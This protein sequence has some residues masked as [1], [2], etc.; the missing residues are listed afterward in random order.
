M[1]TAIEVENLGKLYRIQGRTVPTLKTTVID[2][3]R[4]RARK[5]FWALRH[6]T[7]RVPKGITFGVI[8]ANG[9]GKSTLLGLIAGTLTP[10]EGS[11][12]AEGKISTLLELGA[13]FHPEL[14]GRENVFLNAAILGIPREEIRKRFDRIVEF[15]GLSEFI[16]TPVKFYSSGMYVRLGFAVAIEMD[17]D[18]LLIDEVLAVGD[19]SFQMKCLD[20]IQQFQREGRT[21]LIVSHSMPVIED[22]CDEVILLDHG[23]K[24]NQGKAGE[25]V[26][27]YLRITLG[28]D[29]HL[30]IEEHGSRDVEMVSVRFEDGAG[31]ETRQ[32][33]DGGAMRVR[34]RYRARRR[35]ERPVFGFSVKRADG[36]HM[37][38]TN[39]QLMN[40]PIPAVEGAGEVV[41]DL[42]PLHLLRGGY[43]LSLSIHSWDHS[44]QYH[45][46]EDWY[47]F[48]VRN[49]SG[50]EGF[51][52]IPCRWEWRPDRGGEPP[53]Q[54]EEE[55][56]H[57]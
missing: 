46:R 35:V 20:K 43:Y 57:E 50:D 30:N 56:H 49:R 52:R 45:R 48:S 6:V 3:L 4:R 2:R 11:I 42:S 28:R 22:V 12:R 23:H 24:E 51:V 55:D 32:F 9:S 10:T 41:L 44:I 18:I 16:D 19:E 36:T 14:T 25:V 17:P 15:S 34:I 7:F 27:E 8:G 38:G 29:S 31:R 37:F 1:S 53:P 40:V 47:S 5:P 13:G 39:T 26:A 21:L 33:E 54:E